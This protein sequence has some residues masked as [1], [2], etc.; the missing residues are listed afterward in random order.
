VNTER[1]VGYQGDKVGGHDAVLPV[2]PAATGEV[3]GAQVDDVAGF[4]RGGGRWEHVE[5][6][7]GDHHL[8][9][10]KTSKTK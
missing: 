9:T 3:A 8:K 1:S 10:W 2:P 6:S 7:R 5:K 4:A